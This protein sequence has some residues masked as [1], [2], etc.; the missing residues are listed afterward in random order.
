MS[1]PEYILDSRYQTLLL[2]VYDLTWKAP[3]ILLPEE[4][5]A[6]LAQYPQEETVCCSHNALFDMAILAWRYGWV[7]GRMQDT[8]GMVRALRNY[9]R[10]SLGEVIKQ[11]FS[12]DTK[13][14][15]LHKV[16]GLDAA[17]IKRMGLWPSYCEYAM[18]DVRECANIYLKLAPEF[19]QEERRVMDLVLRA[20]VCP[21]LHADVPLLNNHLEALRKRKAALLRDCGYDKAAL[22]STLQFQAVLSDLGVEIQ[23]KTNA[24][25]K[26]I[27]AF[28]KSD[29]FMADLLEYEQDSDEETNYAVQTLAAARL[30]HKSTIEETRTER[31]CNIANLR[32][33]GCRPLLPMPLRYGGAHTHRL[34]GEWSMNVQNLPRDKAKSKLRAALCAPPEHTLITADLAQIE[35]RIVARICQQ[36]DLVGAFRNGEDVY[37]SFA[38]MVFGRNVTKQDNERFIGKTAVLGLGYGC[39]VD[40]FH[41]MVC[42]LARQYGI[43]LEGL[44]DERVAQRTVYLYR[45]LFPRIKNSWYMLDTRLDRFINSPN[46]DN[47]VDWGPVTIMSSRIRLPNNMYL[48]YTMRD[49]DL[50]GA[51]ILENI[52]QALARIVLMQAALRL[53]QKGL[54][55]VLQAHDE[56]VFVVQNAQVKEAKQIIS[57]EMVREPPWLDGLPLAVEVGEGQNYG[58]CK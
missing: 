57:V 30:S 17:G 44:F 9:K 20:A 38:S 12:R 39:G 48:R 10:N 37:A 32:W 3:K 16:I 35:A 4:I 11:L 52:T 43:N 42:T 34:S 7:A 58:A 23:T 1:P 41:Q 50:Y 13:G 26:Q 55:F 8:L 14:D 15:T 27:P 31:F 28:A 53:A 24:K 2:A 36:N 51:K 5:P 22:M 33:E 49:P 47:K 40:R 18:N 29:P 56:L 19:P 45:S 46:P 54:R 21:T 6:F 25:G